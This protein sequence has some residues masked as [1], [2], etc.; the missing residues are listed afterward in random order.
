MSVS[1]EGAELEVAFADRVEEA[2][3]LLASRAAD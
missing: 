1:T 2:V 3:A